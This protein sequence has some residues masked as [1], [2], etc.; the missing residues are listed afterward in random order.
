[1]KVD[2]PAG[3]YVV[4]VS[5]G[6]DS[7]VLLDLLSENPA[8]ELVVAHFDHGIRADSSADAELVKEAAA[9]YGYPF[10]LGHGKL[11]PKTSEENA[12]RARYAFLNEVKRKY[13][14]EAIITAHHQDDA[15][16]TALINLL[17]GTGPKGLISLT[18]TA[19]IKRPLLN[20]PKSDIKKYA[21][22][23][24]IAWREDPS[25]PQLNYLRNYLRHRT[26][27]ALS[28]EDRKAILDN[29]E[30]VANNNGLQEKIIATLSHNIMLDGKIDRQ[31]FI[32]F[33]SPVSNE[34]LADWLRKS[35]YRQFD[36]KK[37]GS[38]GVFIRT[39]RPG[40]RFD[41]SKD[42]IICLSELSA[43]LE[44]KE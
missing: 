40:A 17:R 10:E 25:N 29:L 8:L 1:M 11:G 38:A 15:I 13:Q 18:N 2:V 43:W 24:I 19:L 23:H 41:V 35:G 39:G 14:A 44:R 21:K 37:V 5:G 33:P 7:M 22:R 20:Y 31:A 42:L 16:E 34:L 27:A 28:E 3:K 12:R 26:L 32:M 36:R 4:A 30:K 9:K 6:V